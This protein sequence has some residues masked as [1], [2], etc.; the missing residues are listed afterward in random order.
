MDEENTMST[1]HGIFL[2]LREE[3]NIW[4]HVTA[5]MKS[6]GPY[7]K[8]VMPV[9]L[10]ANTVRCH[11]YDIYNVVKF[12]EAKSRMGVDRCWGRDKWRAAKQ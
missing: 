12:T 6:W 11:F 10:R 3:G 5:L 2:C 9:T 4:K 1:H 8:W 7:A